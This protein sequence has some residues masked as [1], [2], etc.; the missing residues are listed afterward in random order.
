MYLLT[1]FVTGQTNVLWQT[2]FELV[3]L[4]NVHVAH[5]NL[6]YIKITTVSHDGRS[7]IW[8]YRY[9]MKVF[10]CVN[11]SW[12]TLLVSLHVGIGRSD[13][14]VSAIVYYTVFMPLW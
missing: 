2:L 6:Y 1:L 3:G 8:Y 9:Y 11:A 7:D 4:T 10:Y 13:R 5:C 14:C 12:Q